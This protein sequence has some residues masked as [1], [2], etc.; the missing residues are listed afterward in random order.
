MIKIVSKGD[1]ILHEED[2]N[3][4]ILQLDDI[5]PLLWEDENVIHSANQNFVPKR[6]LSSGKYRLYKVS[7]E[8]NL[9]DNYHLE[10]YVGSKKWQGYL[11]PTNILKMR[12]QA[13]PITASNELISVCN[14]Q[15][16]NCTETS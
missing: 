8:P 1:Y 4:K 16:S 7:N 2:K 6:I 14:C 5:K 12:K 11:L 15:C 10:L 9:T 13:I 3:K